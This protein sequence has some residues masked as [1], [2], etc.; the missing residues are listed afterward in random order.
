MFVQ[1][2]PYQMLMKMKKEVNNPFY[3]QPHLPEL[4][5]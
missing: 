4:L 1:Q 5:K 3:A 2:Q